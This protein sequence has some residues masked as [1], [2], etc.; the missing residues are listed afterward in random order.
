M[1][2]FTIAYF[3][4]KGDSVDIYIRSGIHRGSL[5]EGEMVSTHHNLL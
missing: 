2:F 1:V 4:C 3:H 5:L